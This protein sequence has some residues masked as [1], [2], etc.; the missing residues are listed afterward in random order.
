MATLSRVLCYEKNACREM[1]NSNGR[2]DDVL[3][4]M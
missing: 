1:V 4:E 2:L 3:Q